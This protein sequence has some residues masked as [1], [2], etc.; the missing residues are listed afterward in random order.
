[1]PRE[2]TDD[3]DADKY[4]ADK[5]STEELLQ[6][7]NLPSKVD[8]VTADDVM[9]VTSSNITKYK[10]SAVSNQ[11]VSPAKAATYLQLSLFFKEIQ[12]KL[13]A[14]V[15]QSSI[16]NTD[17]DKAAA[18]AR[19]VAAGGGW[20]AAVA[21][22]NASASA[23]IRAR[24]RSEAAAAAAAATTPASDPASIAEEEE[25][26][27]EPDVT[28][29]RQHQQQQYLPQAGG[30][31]AHT[32]RSNQFELSR[33]VN[34]H[35]TMTQRWLGVP[36]AYTVPIA[37]GT[38]NPTLR[39]TYRRI[40]I[41]NSK[42]RAVLFPH[43][44]DPTAPSSSTNFNVQLSEELKNVVSLHMM[45]ITVPYAWYAVD[46]ATGT[47]CLHMTIIFDSQNQ[48]T[49]TITVPTGNYTPAE[50]VNAIQAQILAYPDN[51]DLKDYVR[52]SYSPA[53]GLCT[54]HNISGTN[55]IAG[56]TIKLTFF[57]PT[58]KLDCAAGGGC[59]QTSKIN[60]SLGWIL[61]FR[62]ND[63]HP[64]VLY[65]SF[66]L[67][68]MVYTVAANSSLTGEAVVDTYG[69]K[70]FMIVLDDYKNNR[71]NCGVVS[72]TTTET[73]LDAPYYDDGDIPCERIPDPF[74]GPNDKI[75]VNYPANPRTLTEGQLY[76][77]NEIR[78]NRELTTVDRVAEPTASN[79]FAITHVIKSGL[80]MGASLTDSSPA[81]AAHKREYFGP[82]TLQRFKVAL[83]DDNGFAVNL[84]GNDW[85]FTF[86][87]ESLYEY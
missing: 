18:A 33:D 50:L 65:N 63:V 55:G 84:N 61:G 32:D 54:F 31:P 8:E 59:K 69:P 62:S 52:V 11:L 75:T 13:L 30:G 51:A 19:A 56:L 58:R 47:N 29:A 82:V 77:V 12:V 20:D 2:D 44:S 49:E 26:E 34:E 5:Y 6:L 36:S 74:G 1:M 79:V 42:R 3:D 78:R 46:A 86:S 28:G 22:A 41:I 15:K 83:V 72:I 73:R 10:A 17:A 67:D 27:A 76:T 24:A 35:Y 14:A 45:S 4:N 81:I 40:V 60:N 57:D 39:N 53:N 25:E 37:Q 70:Y 87:A 9:L 48:T 66:A 68:G 80:A 23:S 21:Q 85:S 16:M 43:S 64:T 71:I 38:M 7:L